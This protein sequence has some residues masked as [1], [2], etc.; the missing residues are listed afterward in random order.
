MA[1][2]AERVTRART[3]LLLDHPWF[4]ALALRLR[5]EE[6]HGQ[7]ETMATD[8]TSLIYA[9]AY[10]DTLTDKEIIGVVAHEV[11]H[12]ALKHVFRIGTR[13]LPKWN[14][15][16][17]YAIN[18]LLLA[19]GFQLPEGHLNDPA[20]ADLPA[21]TIYQRLPDE[22][23]GEAPGPPRPDFLKPPDPD[24]LPA[25][26]PPETPGPGESDPAPSQN[27]GPMTEID[28]EI[29]TE[30]ASLVSRKSGKAPAAVMREVE[31]ARKSKTDW[32]TILRRFVENTIPSD[33]SWTTPNRRHIAQGLYLPGSY[34]EN[35]PRLGVGID[36]SGS[37]DSKALSAFASELTAIM[38]EAR[39]VEVEVVYCDAKVQGKPDIFTPD[40]GE[41]KLKPR[42]GGGTAFQ[43]VFDH[44]NKQSEPPA[45]VIYFTDLYGPEPKEPDYPTLW[46]TFPGS[47]ETGPFGETVNLELPG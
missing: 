22:P 41:I 19:D 4:G 34:R 47:I 26:G 13:D 8:G 40:D 37:I 14:K 20:F 1:T 44:F 3:L 36:T 23:P 24:A 10:V 33:Y 25:G 42:G 18:P 21:E 17:D 11:L 43:P 15:A 2:A 45:A 31:H 12:C 39:P 16:C 28:W 7:T 30:E 6:A 46:V 27:T 5:V 35:C 9:P 38:L 29:A 32:R